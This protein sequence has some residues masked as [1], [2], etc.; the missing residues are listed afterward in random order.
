MNK[1]IMKA[2]GFGKEVELVEKKKCPICREDIED[3]EFKDALSRREYMI[4]GLC[5]KCQDETFG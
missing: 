1:D 2:V 3:N 4:S 5:Q